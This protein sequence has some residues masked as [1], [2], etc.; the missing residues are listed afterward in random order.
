M[1]NEPKI[2]TISIFLDAIV[3]IE[4]MVVITIKIDIKDYLIDKAEIGMAVLE[5]IEKILIIE[6]KIEEEISLIIKVLSSGAISDKMT[7]FKEE[8]ILI[9][10]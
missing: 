5:K 6:M 7:G 10:I 3:L 9:I 1:L 2:T 8:E 4:D